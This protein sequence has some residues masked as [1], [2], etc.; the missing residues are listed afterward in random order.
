MSKHTPGEW[1]QSLKSKTGHNRGIYSNA[2]LLIASVDVHQ[3]A[4][5]E[6]RNRREA[7]ARLIAAAPLM[8]E[9]LQSMTERYTSLVASGDAGN[10]D[11]EAEPQV[12]A[13]RAVIAAATGEQP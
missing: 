11:A 1:R 4:A 10:W 7:D 13:A 8:L 6:H 3:L 5:K 2:G 12:I 9:A